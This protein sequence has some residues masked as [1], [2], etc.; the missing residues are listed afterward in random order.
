MKILFPMGK[1][2]I[3][4]PLFFLFLVV[5]AEAQCPPNEDP[6][7]HVVQKGETFYGISR[8]YDLPLADLYKM[9][10]LNENAVLKVCQK[11]TVKNKVAAQPA[12][13]NETPEPE[14]KKSSEI[15]IEKEEANQPDEKPE[16]VPP[17]TAEENAKPFE[18][19]IRQKGK[20][21][22]V[23]PGEKV[24]LIA[25]L[26]GY[27]EAFF[28][29]FNQLGDNEVVAAGSELKSTHCDCPTDDIPVFEDTPPLP[30]PVPEEIQT[31]EPTERDIP[32]PELNTQPVPSENTET[33][34]E[35]PVEE[36]E[37][38]EGGLV[39][40]DTPGPEVKSPAPNQKEVME[41][42]KP[43]LRQ[44]EDTRPKPQAKPRSEE[45]SMRESAMVI[46]INNLRTNPVG[47]ADILSKHLDLIEKSLDNTALK[48]A[49]ELVTQLNSM[50][51]LKPLKPNDCLFEVAKVHGQDEQTRGFAEHIGSD[52]SWPWDR[53]TNS[54]PSFKDGS[55]NLLEEK[56]DPREAILHMLIDEGNVYRPNR[57]NLLRGDW[58]GIGVYRVGEVGGLP[59]NWVIT[60]GK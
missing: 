46:E 39:I 19:Y 15:K 58:T 50:G 55:E 37:M 48:E 26:Y 40:E 52:G 29:E 47:Y 57:K 20:T 49:R 31:P 60:F 6:T 27:T 53:V 32:E 43:V 18:E 22:I 51:P 10:G 34:P 24:A 8:M 41:A 1:K 59:D 28:R 45:D 5:K 4:L 30:E 12:P 13:V 54:C 11:L 25:R 44:L 23:Q 36:E 21:H 16:A 9:N 33:T 14:P 38:Q 56:T 3:L 35:E 7:I 17:T 42:P 2:I